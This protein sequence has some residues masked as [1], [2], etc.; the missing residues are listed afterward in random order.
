MSYV[1]ARLGRGARRLRG[2]VLV[3]LLAAAAVTGATMWR[4]D[5]GPAVGVAPG[6]P[7]KVGVAQ[8][9]SIPGYEE[10]SRTELA[11]L[12]GT[13]QIYALVSLRAYLAPDRLA[14][15]LAGVATAEVFARV[16]IPGVQTEIVR[17]AAFRVPEDVTGGMDQI[18]ARK[19]REAAD[20]A[21]QLSRGADDRL[22]PVY[23]SG[24]R[25]AE[26]EAI[27]Y[28]EHCSCVYA[29]VVRA[30][31]AALAAVAGR[32]EVR[33]VDPAPEVRRPERAVFLPP[34]PQQADVARPPDDSAGQ[35]ASPTLRPR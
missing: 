34:L 8:N 30:A 31:P 7:V 24:R 9:G 25:V 22:R 4:L 29:A 2:L 1:L 27:G 17:F 11:A 33:V 5:R 10:T 14:P 13:G 6:A 3:T 35:A 12:A 20:Y 19:D 32:P 18:A 23:E 15:A 28:R 26:A 21:R 16:P